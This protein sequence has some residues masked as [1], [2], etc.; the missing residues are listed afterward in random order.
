MI[1]NLNTGQLGRCTTRSAN[2]FVQQSARSARRG[3]NVV[4]IQLEGLYNIVTGLL[5]VFRRVYNIVPCP[6]GECAA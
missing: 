1:F 2:R 4:P 3:F 5:G 6:I